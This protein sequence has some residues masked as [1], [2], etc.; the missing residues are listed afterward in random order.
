MELKSEHACAT[1]AN[2]TAAVNVNAIR[3]RIRFD[4]PATITLETVNSFLGQVKMFR[5][6]RAVLNSNVVWSA[7]IGGALS[8]SF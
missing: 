4:I 5:F 8:P 2:T 7:L 6:G 1:T 3:G